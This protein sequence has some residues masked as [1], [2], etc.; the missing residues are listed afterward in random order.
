[1]ADALYNDYKNNCFE[2]IKTVSYTEKIIKDNNSDKYKLLNI[3]EKAIKSAENM[4]N[5]MQLEVETNSLI[6]KKENE[7]NEIHK[8]ITDYKTKL[9]TI[10][11]N[12]LIKEREKNEMMNNYDDRILLLSDVDLLEQGDIYINQSKILMTNSEYISNDV[13]KNLNKQ[14]ESIKKS[15]S[16][17]SFITTKLDQAKT[18]VNILKNKE[19]FNKYRLYIIFI[20]MFLTFLFVTGMKYKKYQNSLNTNHKKQESNTFQDFLKNEQEVNIS[21]HNTTPILPDSPSEYAAVPI[22]GMHNKLDTDQA[23]MIIYDF[24]EKKDSKEGNGLEG[25]VTNDTAFTTET[26][27][28]RSA[29]ISV[30][31]NSRDSEFSSKEIK[32]RNNP[33]AGYANVHA[34]DNNKKSDLIK[35]PNKRGGKSQMESKNSNIVGSPIKKGK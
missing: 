31:G 8:E 14:R 30:N 17:M 1:M 4:F 35:N 29:S 16:N 9:K 28:D 10:K 3:Y 15:L 13:L 23:N 26:T 32:E 24:I 7:L 11:E 6:E 12:F 2:Y 20:F 33:P 5:R 34:G 18:I 25:I 22:N 27:T 21:T 19:L